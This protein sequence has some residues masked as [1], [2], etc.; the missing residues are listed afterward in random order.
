MIP[1]DELIV[2]RGV[3]IPPT[4]Q[5]HIK[6]HRFRQSFP[7][8]PMDLERFSE[9]WSTWDNSLNLMEPEPEL[10]DL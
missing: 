4:S 2:F 1:T 7:W 9:P 8:N 10:V 6:F 3:G 5:N